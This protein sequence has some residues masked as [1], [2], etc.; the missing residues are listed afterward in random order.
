[1]LA[2]LALAYFGVLALPARAIHQSTDAVEGT[3]ARDWRGLFGHKNPASAAMVVIVFAGL[4]L[5]RRWSRWLGI[6]IVALAGYFLLKT[7]GKTAMGMLPAIL[8]LAAAF[9]RYD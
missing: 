8:V 2:V 6:V 1:M 9:E 3:L 7:G 5:M 4:Y